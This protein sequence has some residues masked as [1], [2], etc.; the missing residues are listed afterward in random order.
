MSKTDWIFITLTL[1]FSAGFISYG[2]LAVTHNVEFA[3]WVGVGIFCLSM[4]AALV[5]DTSIGRLDATL[6]RLGKQ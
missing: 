4:A 3:V 1:V 6:E 5:F 2:S